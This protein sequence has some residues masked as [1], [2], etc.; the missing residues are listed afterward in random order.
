MYNECDNCHI[1]SDETEVLTDGYG[2]E[3]RLCYYCRADME[4]EPTAN[5]ISEG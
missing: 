3:S 2:N 1:H 4:R 5:E